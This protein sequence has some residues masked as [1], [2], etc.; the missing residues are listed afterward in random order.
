[1][2]KVYVLIDFVIWS[3]V[4][5]LYDRVLLLLNKM[6]YHVSF[7]PRCLEGSLSLPMDCLAR[8]DE[9]KQFFTLLAPIQAMD[10]DL[11]LFRQPLLLNFGIEIV[12]YHVVV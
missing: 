8:H 7:S 4:T 11:K 5:Q 10:P 9:L 12:D 6:L 1:M 3:L 2:Y